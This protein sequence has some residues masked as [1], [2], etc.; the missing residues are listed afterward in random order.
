MPNR[1]LTSHELE[2]LALPLLKEMRSKLATLSRGDQHLL[3]ALRRKI[4]KELVYDERRKPAHRIALKKRKRK[5]QNN[6][7]AICKEALPPSGAIL[8][9][10]EAMGGYT[11]SNTRLLCPTCDVNVQSQ[12]AYK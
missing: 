4:A 6:L 10:F 8:D 9:R 1:Q 5:E 2:T 7:C 12:R 11:A 3:W